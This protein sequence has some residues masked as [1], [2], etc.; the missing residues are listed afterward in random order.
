VLPNTI[1]TILGALTFKHT[2][3]RVRH[4]SAMQLLPRPKRSGTTLASRV[5]LE[6]LCQLMLTTPSLPTTLLRCR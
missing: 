2:A 4:A 1:R 6:S 5:E 3:E